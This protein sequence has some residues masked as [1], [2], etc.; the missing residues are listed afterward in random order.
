[1][2]PRQQLLIVSITLCLR[3]MRPK[4]FI[5][6][7]R[8][9]AVICVC[10]CFLKYMYSSCCFFHQKSPLVPS[11][12]SIYETLIRLSH[13]SCFCSVQK[14]WQ[15]QNAHELDIFVMLEYFYIPVSFNHCVR[16]PAVFVS[17]LHLQTHFSFHPSLHRFVV[18]GMR[19]YR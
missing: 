8:T 10:V 19:F 6:P 5:A 16:V 7:I 9:S 11:C 12:L 13:H 15:D 18:R 14:Y 17:W 1:M 3:T 2:W 4:N